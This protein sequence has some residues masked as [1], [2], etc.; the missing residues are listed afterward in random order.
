M[1][2]NLID[3]LQSAKPGTSENIDRA[4]GRYKLP[5][6]VVETIKYLIKWLKK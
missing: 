6:G 3:L 1:I 2:T 5:S 4:I